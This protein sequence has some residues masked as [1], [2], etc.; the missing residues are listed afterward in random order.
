MRMKCIN[1]VS[2]GEYVKPVC[3][4]FAF[5]IR[6]TKRNPLFKRSD[7]TR[8]TKCTLEKNPYFNYNLTNKH[9]SCDE[10]LSDF[11]AT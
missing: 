3:N 2:T 8:K 10:T 1:K 5:I 4:F 7:K 9:K 11:I 6:K